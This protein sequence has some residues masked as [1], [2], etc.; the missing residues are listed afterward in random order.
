MTRGVR[1]V[2][3]SLRERKNEFYAVNSYISTDSVYIS[4]FYHNTNFGAI[5]QLFTGEYLRT[6]KNHCSIK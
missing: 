6:T 4:Q 1:S 5:N 2:I 3:G